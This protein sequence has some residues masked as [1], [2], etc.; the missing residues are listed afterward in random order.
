MSKLRKINSAQARVSD[1][2]TAISG[3]LAERRGDLITPETANSLVAMESLD[4]TTLNA[5]EDTFGQAQGALADAGLENLL[6]EHFRGNDHAVQVSMEAAAITLLAA[7][8]P[9]V[10]HESFIAAR[11]AGGGATTVDTF[12]PGVDSALPSME[13]FTQDSFDKFVSHSVLVN[14]LAVGNNEFD[15]AFFPTEVIDAS[16][17]GA[18]VTVSIAY[19]YNRTKR[20]V[21]GKPYEFEKKSL[22]RAIEDHTILEG[23][24]TDVYPRADAAANNDAF[25]VDAAVVGNK[26]LSVNGVDIVTRPLKFGV[27][28]DLLAVSNHPGLIGSDGQDETDALDPNIALGSVY[29]E[30]AVDDG[31]AVKK[32]VFEIDTAGV[33]GALF[34]RAAEG[35]TSNLTMS[36]KSA[37]GLNA[38]M[39]SVGGVAITDLGLHTLLGVAAGDDWTVEVPVSISGVANNEYANIEVYANSVGVGK[40][41]VGTDKTPMATSGAE[42]QAMAA[43]TTVALV[44]YMPKARR[45]NANLRQKGILI[46]TA[47]SNRYYYP[48]T[49][50]SPL[51]SVRPVKSAGGGATVEGLV[52]ALRTR[53]SNASVSTLMHAEAQLKQLANDGVVPVNAPMI[54]S[55]FVKPTYTTRALDAASVVTINRSGEGYDDLRALLVDAVT[56]MADKLALESGYLA[57]LEQFT[58]GDREYEIIVGT[59]PRIAGLLMKSG[60]SRTFGENRNYRIVSSLDIRMRD[61]IYVSFRRVSQRGVDPL[62]FGAHLFMPALVHEVAN[63]SQGGAT[64]QE[65][66]VQPRELHT[67]TLPILGRIDVTNLEE[68]YVKP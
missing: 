62:S 64:V 37:L 11:K 40:A 18:E 21:N 46:D 26:T 63:S 17:S 28:T 44:G 39:K 53:S 52:Q 20:G 25:L 42:Y 41:Y 54:G 68:F 7:G 66:Q 61:R 2:V 31:T 65:I 9:E 4:E 36:F 29:L 35:S 30:V 22:I 19:A 60:D 8:N 58:G 6:R 55:L 13:S 10:Y 45:V 34:T 24:S 23:S 47:Q 59:D 67:A 43:A 57:A 16:Q 38:K 33:P 49:I 14:A 3:V 1:I 27:E 56:T 32:H 51:A 50:G 12:V 15:E 48:I 5:L